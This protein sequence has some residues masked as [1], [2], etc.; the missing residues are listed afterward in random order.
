MPGLD[1]IRKQKLTSKQWAWVIALAILIIVVREL[2][3]GI[4]FTVLNILILV[5]AIFLSFFIYAEKFSF[6]LGIASIGAGAFAHWFALDLAISSGSCSAVYTGEII[7][8]LREVD[9]CIDY[10]EGWVLV[11][12]GF[13]IAGSIVVISTTFKE[14]NKVYQFFK[15]E[16]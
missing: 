14:I 9:N 1:L 2:S 6:L 12:Q 16:Y 8:Y 10:S 15:Y 5:Y 13:M 7:S 4:Y 11:A 3:S